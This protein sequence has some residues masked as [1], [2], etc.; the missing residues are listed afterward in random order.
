MIIH[1][2]VDW[3]KTDSKCAF[4]F[5]GSMPK[6][7]RGCRPTLSDVGDLLSRLRAECDAPNACVRA[8]IEPGSLCWNTLFHLA[9]AA[10]VVVDGKQASRFGESRCSSGAKDDVRDA[11]NLAAF[12]LSP[13]H[14]GKAW[15]PMEDAQAEVK[16]LLKD[17]D[18][19]S[20]HLGELLQRLRSRIEDSMLCVSRTMVFTRKW[21]VAFFE[22]FPTPQHLSTLAKEDFDAFASEHRLSQKTRAKLWSA[23]RDD[24]R[25]LTKRQ[26]EL[27][28]NAVGRLIRMI[29]AIRTEQS[30]CKRELEALLADI[31]EAK[32][33]RSVPGIGPCLTAAILKACRKSDTGRDDLSIRL[34][35]APVWR[36]SG[37]TRRGGPKGRTR[38]RMS[39]PAMDRR[40]SYLLGMQ[41]S[42]RCGW[43][44]AKFQIERSKGKP[45]AAIYRGIAR[46]VLRIIQALLRDGRDYD[47][48]RYIKALKMRG[49]SW[50]MSIQATAA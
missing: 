40:A 11:I 16:L 37:R 17:Y 33:I 49:L 10:V 8:F 32:R 27:G 9:G 14:H 44:K 6:S 38:M 43:A 50:A 39:V 20:R 30:A 4:S 21:P 29:L 25:P 19:C 41:V 2:G 31:P 13:V 35:A 23:I 5:N 26:T 15:T 34:G 24:A 12:G 22:L 28:T 3:S 47:D 45:A 42:H 1:L 48:A 18:D 7:I 36:G 46:S